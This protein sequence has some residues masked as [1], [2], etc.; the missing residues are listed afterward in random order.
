[1]ELEELSRLSGINAQ[2]DLS[3]NIL[4]L[5]TASGAPATEFSMAEDAIVGMADAYWAER[6]IQLPGLIRSK[7]IIL[8]ALAEFKTKK[9]RNVQPLM[10]A[11]ADDIVIEPIRPEQFTGPTSAIT[12]DNWRQA[13]L[14]AGAVSILPNAAQVAGGD[15]VIN[16][17][18]DE[19]FIITDWVE[20]QPTPIL[21]AMQATSD[22][23]VY[24]PLEIRWGTW[25]GGLSHY[26]MDYP[27]IFDVTIDI[28]AKCEFNGTSELTPY[29]VHICLGRLIANLT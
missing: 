9:K 10:F 29:G 13:G 19:L 3:R 5:K 18:D 2:A 20:H 1:M 17:D 7:K 23:Y 28:N 16:V 11:R 25:E 6:H 21:S 24:N 26:A 14:V 12:L 4:A 27:W 15:T 8:A 22:N